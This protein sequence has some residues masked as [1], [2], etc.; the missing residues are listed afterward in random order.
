MYVSIY[1]YVY[2]HKMSLIESTS[3][4]EARIPNQALT[5]AE[6][7]R[8]NPVSAVGGMVFFVL[9]GTAVSRKK[10]REETKIVDGKKHVNTV[11]SWVLCVCVLFCFVCLFVYLFIWHLVS[12]TFHELSVFT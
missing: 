2:V 5:L 12:L 4:V 7:Y 6:E 9:E 3:L 1:R 10:E 11:S 8:I